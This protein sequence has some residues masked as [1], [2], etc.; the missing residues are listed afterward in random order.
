MTGLRLMNWF[1]YRF[2]NG[3]EKALQVP[4][5]NVGNTCFAHPGQGEFG[6]DLGGDLVALPVSEVQPF[7]LGLVLRQGYGQVDTLFGELLS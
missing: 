5:G 1:W 6:V 4:L 2:G 7:D 3:G